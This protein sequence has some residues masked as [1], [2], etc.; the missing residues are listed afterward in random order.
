[1]HGNVAG[2]RTGKAP[3]DCAMPSFANVGTVI[4][5]PLEFT[6]GLGSGRSCI[7]GEKH[8]RGGGE[9]V[10]LSTAILLVQDECSAHGCPPKMHFD[11]NLPFIRAA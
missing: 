5:P 3:K 6:I 2:M 4:L 1:M 11:R 10:D 8:G 7:V 9:F